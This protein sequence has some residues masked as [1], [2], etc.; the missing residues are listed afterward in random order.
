M[1]TV[2]FWKGKKHKQTNI[3]LRWKES[4]TEA[5]L[6]HNPLWSLNLVFFSTP[7]QQSYWKF[8][9]WTSRKDKIISRDDNELFRV[10]TLFFG[11][12]VGR[13]RVTTLALNLFHPRLITNANLLL[14]NQ[15]F[16]SNRSG[17]YIHTQ[18]VG[19]YLIIIRFHINLSVA[20]V[21]NGKFNLSALC[22]SY[23]ITVLKN[24]WFLQTNAI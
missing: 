21:I 20:F 15:A 16:Y 24:I 8:V 19:F 17:R 2:R 13:W 9:L 5:E 1:H 7:Y 22:V 10:K 14:T 12:K 4:P 11:K 23:S 18:L 6:I 3:H